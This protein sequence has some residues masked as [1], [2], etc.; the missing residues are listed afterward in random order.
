MYI[1]N[2]YRPPQGNV[3]KFIEYLRESLDLIDDKSKKDVFILGDF[4][5]DF[6]KKSDQNTKDLIQTMNTFGMKQHIVGITRYGKKNSCIDL[7]FSNSEYINNSGILDLN[8]SDHQAVYITKKKLKPEK[9]KIEFTGRSYK[10]YDID[11]LQDSLRE[12]DWVEFFSIEDPNE[13]WDLLY[14]RIIGILDIM[15]PEKKFKVNCYREDWMNKDLMERIIDKDKALKKAK[16]N[17]NQ[18]D[19]EKAKKLRNE[20]GNLIELAKKHHFQEE[21]ENSREDPKRFWRNIY[22]IIPKNKDRKSNIHLKNEYGLEVNFDDTATFIN[23]YFT[24]IGPN[25]ASKFNEN[26]NYF[27]K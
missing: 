12:L 4:N 27:G 22:D 18:S 10:N 9:S 11:Y 24:N 20:V 15:C 19:W 1:A 14:N 17:N 25:L 3:K 6:K 16:K 23:D 8:F 13:S 5:I 2:V 26:W 21:Y 7:I